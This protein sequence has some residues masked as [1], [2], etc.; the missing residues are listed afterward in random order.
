MP[1]QARSKCHNNSSQPFAGFGETVA[2]GTKATNIFYF[3]SW[4][5]C[6]QR[7]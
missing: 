4:H 2:K 3:S 6:P 5:S 1:K 7:G